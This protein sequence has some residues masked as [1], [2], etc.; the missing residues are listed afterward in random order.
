MDNLR[1]SLNFGKLMERLL[2][3]NEKGYGYVASVLRSC[4]CYSW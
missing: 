4:C 2:S 1:Y 3:F